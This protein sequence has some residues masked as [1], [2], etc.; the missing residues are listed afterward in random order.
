[1]LRVAVALAF[2]VLACAGCSN[3]ELALELPA[4]EP[5]KLYDFNSKS[6]RLL[7]PGS[8]AHRELMQW[9]SSHRHGWAPYFATPPALGITVRAGQLHLQFMETTVLAHTSEGVFERSVAPAEYA[10]L[11]Q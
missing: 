6:E 2:V 11:R 8:V 10:F 1:M 4:A 5:V 3:R 7:L 9:V